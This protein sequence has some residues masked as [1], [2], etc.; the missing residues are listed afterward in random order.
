[1]PPQNGKTI[2][3]T[4]R[5]SRVINL[6]V[7]GASEARIAEMEGVAQSTIFKDVKRYLRDLAKKD[8]RH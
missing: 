7:A 2:E 8:G 3:A 1:M 5:R 6:K 4:L